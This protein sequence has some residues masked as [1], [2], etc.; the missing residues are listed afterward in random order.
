MLSLLS[1]LLLPAVLAHN[2]TTTTLSARDGT[3]F[4]NYYAGAGEGACGEWHQDSEYVVAL[5]HLDWNNGAN[6]GKEVYIT[7]NGMSAVAKIVDECMGCPEKGLDASQG[8]F[9]HFVGGVQNDLSVGIIYVDWSYGTGPSSGGDSGGDDTTTTTKKSRPRHHHLAHHHLHH[10]HHLHYLHHFHHHTHQHD[11]HLVIQ[12]DHLVVQQDQQQRDPGRGEQQRI[13]C[14][15]QRGGGAAESAG[16]QPGD[17]ECVRVP[18]AGPRVNPLQT[19]VVAL[20]LTLHLAFLSLSSSLHYS[21]Y[22]VLAQNANEYTFA[23]S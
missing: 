20:R 13:G 18:C 21:S 4:S 1:L 7:Y 8:L 6:C 3:Y 19:C 14:E 9:G 11:D 16:L 12:H 15:R 10:L 23:S 5:T 22:P 2:I 17:F